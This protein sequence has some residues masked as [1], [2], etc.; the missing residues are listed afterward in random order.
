M[1]RTVAAV[2]PF[3]PLRAFREAGGSV[4]EYSA[5]PMS[6]RFLI[7]IFVS[8]IAAL[9]VALSAGAWVVFGVGG[10]VGLS[11][12]HGESLWPFA[13]LILG[14]AVVGSWI[15]VR[16]WGQRSGQAL[17]PSSADETRRLNVIK[18]MFSVMV[19]LSI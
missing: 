10:P 15:S 12:P 18:R 8:D 3:A 6:R 2:G 11:I 4:L 7:S 14:G 5:V 9:L 16:T 19:I 17:G 1:T 13:V